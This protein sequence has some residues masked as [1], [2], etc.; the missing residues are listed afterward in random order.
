MCNVC[1]LSLAQDIKGHFR[2]DF[3]KE[4]TLRTLTTCLLHRDFGLTVD[5]PAGN[6]V[7][8]LTLRLNYIHW[9][10]DI[11]RV[12][13]ESD[14]EEAS[15]SSASVSQFARPVV[16]IDI[17]C[18]ASC[19]YPLLA[20]RTNSTWRMFALESNAA[21]AQSAVHNVH[22]NHMAKRIQVILQQMVPPPP[23]HAL[24]ACCPLHANSDG[25]S[26]SDSDHNDDK[27]T[28]T[29]APPLMP[30]F[31]TL[32][33]A[34]CNPND[35]SIIADENAGQHIADFCMCNPPFFTDAYEK[36]ANRTGHRP[37]PR[38]RL[39]GFATTTAAAGSDAY[40]SAHELAVRGG[41]TAFIGRIIAE[42]VLLQ[43]R[44][45]V[46]S[47]MIG[48]KANVARV[49]EMLAAHGI[50]NRCQTVFGQGRT[51]RW[52]VAWSFDDRI[53]LSRVSV[54]G[55]H[56]RH[57]AQ[58][59]KRG[60][61]KKKPNLIS[62]ELTQASTAPDMMVLVEHL[63]EILG[64]IEL[65]PQ[66]VRHAPD[67]WQSRLVATESLWLNERRRRREAQRAA[68]A[69]EQRTRDG[70][71]SM[72]VDG[73]KDATAT[74]LNEGDCSSGYV[75]FEGA[76]VNLSG[77]HANSSMRSRSPDDA[78]DDASGAGGDHEVTDGSINSTA[79]D[80]DVF[81]GDVSGAGKASAEPGGKRVRLLANS[82]INND[83][84][85]ISANEEALLCVDVSIVR[86]TTYGSANYTLDMAYV[87]GTAGREGAYQLSQYVRNH[88]KL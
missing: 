44:I 62:F 21:S 53:D 83:A 22:H 40:A 16:G 29:T 24:P 79:P 87:D 76:D 8:T 60:D 47:T 88:W 27:P 71:D 11:M 65:R 77:S 59:Q 56:V 35:D 80:E 14:A 43:R 4:Q 6:L 46:Y 38:R 68:A 31:D 49:C 30:I 54:M 25:T 12:K 10:E 84:S 72:D 57:Q 34:V 9:M 74:A 28:T 39:D 81:Y 67:M 70:G 64:A 2:I 55:P 5:L 51:L 85:A 86:H 1:C 82:T 48:H 45:R 20:T 63:Q 7:P 15:A 26:N 3:Q 37:T 58:Q 61:A 32:L 78:H 36:P 41:E 50:Q 52:A 18:G 13:A 33:R 19:I 69:A 66:C 73:G 75:E 42:S 23:T 17:G